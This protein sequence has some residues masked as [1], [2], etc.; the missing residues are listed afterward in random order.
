MRAGRV[1]W[2]LLGLALGAC[3]SPRQDWRRG[4][5]VVV[6]DLARPELRV[7]ADGEVVG[8]HAEL[9]RA[10]ARASDHV[11]VWNRAGA[12][13][14]LELLETGRADLGVYPETVGEEW[15]DRVDSMPAPHADL[16]WRVTPARAGVL[17]DLRLALDRVRPGTADDAGR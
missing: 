2:P 1:T 7:D 9:L 10:I 14:A 17:A 12:D 6:S 8:E 4:E 13:R 16:G 3:A 5:W 15:G 11:L